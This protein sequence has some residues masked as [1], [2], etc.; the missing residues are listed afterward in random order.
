M[1]ESFSVAFFCISMVFLL[2]GG[3]YVLAVLFTD[4]VKFIETKT[5]K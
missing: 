5:N 2:L 1:A 4:A 3:L